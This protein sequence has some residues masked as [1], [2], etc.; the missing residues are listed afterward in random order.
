MYTYICTC[1]YIYI[2]IYIDIC[3]GRVPSDVI[4]DPTPPSFNVEH[5]IHDNAFG[6]DVV[7]CIPA[8]SKLQ[9]GSL[10]WKWDRV[11]CA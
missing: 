2:Y 4:P 1:I 11:I 10:G 5:E 9:L 8:I 7:P 3:I 6:F